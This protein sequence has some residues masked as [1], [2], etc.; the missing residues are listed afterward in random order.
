MNT[1]VEWSYDEKT[2]RARTVF[3]VETEAKEGQNRKT[4]M[5][6]YPHQWAARTSELAVRHSYESVRGPIRL[7][8]GNTF[9]NERAFH[10]VLP[11]WAGLEDPTHKAAVDSILVGDT[12]KADQL[13]TKKGRGTYWFGKALGGT[14][15]LLSVA[16]AE[17]RL[18]ARDALLA[19][20]KERLE[21]WYDGRHATYFMQDEGIGTFVGHPQEYNSITDMNDHHF[22][23]GYWLMAAAHIALRD[24]AW[25][26]AAKW[27]GMTDKLVA[28]IA[29]A[30]R[31]RADFPFLRNFDPYEGHSWASGI[32]DFDAGN[33][34][35][36]SSEAV[37]AWAALVLLG[38][39]T[40]NSRLRDLGVYLYTTEVA[41]IEQYWF[42]IDHQVLAPEF[43]KPFASMV[44]GGKY[45]YNTWWTE[46]PRQILGINILPLTPASTY[47]AQDPTYIEHAMAALPGDVHAYQSR[48]VTDGTQA[49]IWQDVLAS[50]QALRDPDAALAAWDRKGTVEFGETRTHTLYWLLSLKEMGAPDFSVTADTSLYAVFKDL[51]GRRTYLAWNARDT[52]LKVSFSD[53]KTLEVS[54]HTLGRTH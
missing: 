7:I 9:A 2:S 10:G 28:D 43:G 18:Q 51:K 42:D 41:A 8:E 23:Y 34:Q 19:K 4:W 6:L 14:A 52:P 32:A 49:D 17:G 36:S 35:E 40:G 47:L 11:T 16:E 53:G 22:H 30:E 25:G 39:A 46:E 45:A 29:T 26:A 3:H 38:E 37:N 24:P 48:G 20:L 54:A 13:Y 15:Q 44:F 27:G 12:V 31:G 33:N 21:T 50:F 1:R 5:G